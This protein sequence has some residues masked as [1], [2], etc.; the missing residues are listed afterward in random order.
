[1]KALVGADSEAETTAPEPNRA[2]RIALLD[3]ARFPPMSAMET[4]PPQTTPDLDQLISDPAKRHLGIATLETRRSDRLDFH[5]V[6]VWAARDALRAAWEAG[7]ASAA[8]TDCAR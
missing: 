4:T 3:A 2:G 1:M 8:A 5:E 6:A 7:R